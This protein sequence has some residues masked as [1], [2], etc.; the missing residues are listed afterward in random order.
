MSR[1][2]VDRIS[3]YQSGS[4]QIDGYQAEI[5]TGSFATT[6]SN[7]FNG[8]QTITGSLILDGGFFDLTPYP[9]AFQSYFFRN[10]GSITLNNGATYQAVTQ[11]ITN[12][13]A[14]LNGKPNGFLTKFH[15][16]ASGAQ[17][18]YTNHW[19]GPRIA[20]HE[21]RPSGS[22]NESQMQLFNPDNAGTTVFGSF[23]ADEISIGTGFASSITIGN[24]GV[25][26]TIDTALKITESDPLPGG[27]TGQLAVSGSNLYYHDGA[28]WTQIN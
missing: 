18:Y 5:N 3:P 1:I 17:S 14:G 22:A 19:V 15:Q 20:S 7:T 24:S 9:A 16:L 21:L 26:T 8:N 4:I 13:E 23:Q 27:G 25:T 2:Y 28:S 12:V 11:Q 10:L 6:G